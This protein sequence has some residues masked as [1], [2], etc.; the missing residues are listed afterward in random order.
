MRLSVVIPT[1]NEAAGLAEAIAVLRA[2]TAGCPVQ[3]IVADCASV[4]DTAAIARRCGAI[5]RTGEGVV[6][7]A[8]ACNAGAEVADGDTLLFLHAD[9]TVPHGFDLLIDEALS[10]PGVVGGAFE[11]QLD[12]PQ[13]RLRLVEWINR[14]RYRVRGRFFGD[15]GIFVRRPIFERIGGFPNIGL[16]EDA[17][18]CADARHLGT[19]RLIKANMLT[20]PRRFYNGGI[21]RTLAMDGTI[22]LADMMGLSPKWFAGA[23]VQDNIRRGT[24]SHRRGSCQLS[25]ISRQPKNVADSIRLI[26]ES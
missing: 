13:R 2:R 21:L 7:R 12:G 5:L 24:P 8:R 20:S 3:V 14:L 26:A 9:S 22:V 11:F 6:S 4:D 25:A 16:L 1:L 23:Y 19:M 17:R 18:F 10:S 15:Q